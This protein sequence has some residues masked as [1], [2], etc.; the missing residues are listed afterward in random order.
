MLPSLIEFEVAYTRAEY[1]SISLECIEH[2]LA[3]RA[4]A[5]GKPVP[6]FDMLSR[7]LLVLVGSFRFWLKRLRMPKNRFQIDRDGIKRMNR[8]GTVRHRWED[9]ATVI[10]CREAY[11]LVTKKGG[12]PLPYR[13]FSVAERAGIDKLLAER[14]GLG[15]ISCAPAAS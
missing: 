13:C 4:R 1:L 8:R 10:H 15:S 3:Q 14:M 9:L 11:V 2:E 12:M 7:G 6:R 5:K